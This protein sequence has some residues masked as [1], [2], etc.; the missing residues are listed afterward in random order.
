MLNELPLPQAQWRGLIPHQGSMCLLEQV[1]RWDDHSIRCATRSHADPGNPLRRAGRLS[2]LHLA[3]YG[4]QAMAIHG[5]LQAARENRRA[6]PGYLA[7]LRDLKLN[8]EFLEQVTDELVI[9]AELLTSGE[10]GWMYRFQAQADGRVLASGR[11]SVMHQ[12]VPT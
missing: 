10:T 7:S 1:L 6:P 8:I 9:E 12:P 11:V 3:E 4:A 5:G 2:A